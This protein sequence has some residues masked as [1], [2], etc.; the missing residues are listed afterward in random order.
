MH[1]GVG[2][3]QS[4]VAQ[5]IPPVAVGIVQLGFPETDTRIRFV[6]AE[7]MIY[8]YIC[9]I[10]LLHADFRIEI[11]CCGRFGGG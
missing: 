8:D 5:E 9:L 2:C 11:L 3:V 1:G 7:V 4:S 6:V 10:Y